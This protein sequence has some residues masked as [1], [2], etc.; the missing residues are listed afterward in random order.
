MSRIHKLIIHFI[1]TAVYITNSSPVVAGCGFGDFSDCPWGYVSCGYFE[2]ICAPTNYCIDGG[3]IPGNNPCQQLTAQQCVQGVN[4]PCT[5][6]NQPTP[7]PAACDNV[8]PWCDE[9]TDCNPNQTCKPQPAGTIPN[10]YGSCTG[11]C[12]DTGAPPPASADCCDPAISNNL[13]CNNAPRTGPCS[14]SVSTSICSTGWRCSYAP[15][16]TPAERL[17]PS[18]IPPYDFCANAPPAEKSTCTDC[19]NNE[20]VW[21][22]LGCIYVEQSTFASFIFLFALGGG[23]GIA[24]L[25]MLYGLFL[26]VTAAGDPEKMTAGKQAITAALIGL[27]FIIFSVIILNLIG[28][29]ILGIPGF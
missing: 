1:I 18:P 11:R 5:A 19:L 23:G 6:P 21:T 20:G 16:P 10:N 13:Q 17:T 29:Q 2:N 12:E 22:A 7:T 25:I 3:E 27:L 4:I 24:F 9:D 28:V 15:T 8:F 14:E 26:I